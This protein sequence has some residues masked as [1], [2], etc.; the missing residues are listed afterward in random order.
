MVLRSAGYALADTRVRF[1]DH[2]P[3]DGLAERRA[4]RNASVVGCACRARGAQRMRHREIAAANG[5]VASAGE[6]REVRLARRDA[7]DTYA[8][9]AGFLAAAKQTVIAHGVAVTCFGEFDRSRGCAVRGKVRLPGA[10][11]ERGPRGVAYLG[12]QR[13]VSCAS[14]G[15]RNR[16]RKGT[17]LQR[18]RRHRRARHAHE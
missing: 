11:A 12:P 7:S 5:L 17:S 15:N 8:I 4:A 18:C 10:A 3:L 13:F 16:E 6:T 14:A 1:G 2:A 9:G